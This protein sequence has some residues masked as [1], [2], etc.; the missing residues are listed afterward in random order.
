METVVEAE[1]RLRRD[2][3]LTIARANNNFMN[4]HADQGE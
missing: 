2:G 4:Q 1:R 3:G